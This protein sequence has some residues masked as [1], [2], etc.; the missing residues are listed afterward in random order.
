M[1]TQGLWLLLL[2]VLS[3]YL[4]GSIPTAYLVGRWIKGIDLREY[5][6]GTVSGSMVFEHV[7]RWLIVPVGLFDVFKGASSTWLGIEIMKEPFRAAIAGIAAVIGHNWPIFLNFTGGRGLS[8]F[9]GVLLILFPPGVIWMLAFMGIGYLLGDSAPWSLA[10]LVS[11]PLLNNWLNGIAA[12]N[13]CA[14]AIILITLIKRLEAN[15]RPLPQDEKERKKVIF[16]R[17]IFDR[18]IQNHKE[19]INRVP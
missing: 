5:G 6:S 3:G 14:G 18:D 9:M 16:Y 4:I 11:L 12:I 19:W 17:L 15:K 2:I 8:P 7:A 10:S 1:D 13:F